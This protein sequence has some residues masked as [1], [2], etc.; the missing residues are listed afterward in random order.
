MVAPQNGMSYQPSGDVY[1]R[2][3][4]HDNP[5]NYYRDLNISKATSTVSYEIDGVKY[6]RTAIASLG[7][8][9]CSTL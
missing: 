6:K 1:L 5:Q 7:K 8:C 4:G 3:K 9:D 2:F